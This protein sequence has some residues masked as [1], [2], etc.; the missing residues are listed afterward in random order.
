MSKTL[1]LKY[2]GNAM[3]V[4]NIKEELIQNICKLHRLGHRVI[5]V[6]G[7]GPYI[8]EALATA[9][10]ESE[11]IAGQRKTSKEA[12]E[13]VEMALKGKVNGDLVRLFNKNKVKGVGLSGKDG[14]I[15]SAKKRYHIEEQNGVSTQQDLG[16]VG[17]VVSVQPQLL[18]QLLDNDFL[19]VITCLASDDQGND[20]N[21]N[22][23]VFA[24]YIA[25]A[26]QADEFIVMTDI[27]GLLRD[28]NDPSSLISELNS[29]DIKELEEQG[30][31]KGGMIPKLEACK[32]ALE[33]GSSMVRIING[34]KPEQLLAIAN[35]ENVGTKVYNK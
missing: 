23:D 18:E 24:G 34:T 29:S 8:K 14:G 30:I 27:D 1:V 11:F 22:G 3:T 28:I 9:K 13:W 25:G 2:G 20:Y 21:I 4:K 16:Q 33:A 17:D 35:N 15:V 19:P 7:G 10:I 12:L 26:M 32:T 5:V 6:H 31:I